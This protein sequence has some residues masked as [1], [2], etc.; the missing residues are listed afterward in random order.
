M[1]YLKPIGQEHVEVKKNLHVDKDVVLFKER[2]DLQD[3]YASMSP[4]LFPRGFT[5]NYLDGKI[6]EKELAATIHKRI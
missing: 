6:N 2:F 4:V 1:S 3:E 5:R